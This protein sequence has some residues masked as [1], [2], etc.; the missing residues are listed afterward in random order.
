VAGATLLHPPLPQRWFPPLLA[1]P[2]S[3]LKRLVA[4]SGE[5]QHDEQQ[6]TRQRENDR[7]V[8]RFL[9]RLLKP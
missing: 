4:A 3:L 7:R 8:D 9:R 6:E 2:T 1:S 5:H